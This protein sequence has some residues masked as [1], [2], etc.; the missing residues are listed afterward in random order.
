VAG[1]AHKRLLIRAV[2]PSL[3]RL[4]VPNALSDPILTVYRGSSIIAEN[5][6]WDDVDNRQAVVSAAAGIGAF[7]LVDSSED[8]ALLITLSPGAYTV[9]IRGKAATEGTALLELYEIP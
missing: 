1:R 2:G 8:A 9:E 7:Q 5:D 6:R 4:G 3:A